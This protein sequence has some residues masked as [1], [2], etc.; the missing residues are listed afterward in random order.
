MPETVGRGYLKKF[1]SQMP[2]IIQNSDIIITVSEFSKKDIMRLFD[3]EEERIM[4]THLAADDYFRPIDRDICKEYLKNNY[5]IDTE[6]LLYIGGFSPRKNVKSILLAYSGLIKEIRDSY[7]VV[8]VGSSKD[9]HS[10]L[11]SLA[12][13][14]NISDNIIFTGYVPYHDLP[15]FYSGATIFLYP[16]LYEGFGLPPLESMNCRTA[17][18]TSNVSSIPEVVGDAALLINPFDAEELKTSIEKLI[19]NEKLRNEI[20]SLNTNELTPIQ[21]LLKI[22]E[23]KELIK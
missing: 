13:S 14:L 5:N 18:I 4:V 2:E 6:Y 10:F 21:A 8:I 12:N 16:S 9:E 15:Y 11:I 1:I 3:V 7:K 22:H 19:E 20:L 17:V 23:W